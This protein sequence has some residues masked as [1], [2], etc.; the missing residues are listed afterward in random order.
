MAYCA[1][2]Y[3]QN[4]LE[5]VSI[6]ESESDGPQ[7]FARTKQFVCFNTLKGKSWIQNRFSWQNIS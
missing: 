4:L 2:E 6:V 5:K 1:K 7:V 3:W